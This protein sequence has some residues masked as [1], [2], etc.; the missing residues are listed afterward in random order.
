M[1]WLH[2]HCPPGCQPPLCWREVPFPPLRMQQ[3]LHH[4]DPLCSKDLGTTAPCAGREGSSPDLYSHHP[5]AQVLHADR[6]ND[7]SVPMNT[8][9]GCI[10][11]KGQPSELPSPPRR[12]GEENQ[13]Q[14]L[15]HAHTHTPPVSPGSCDFLLTKKIL[16]NSAR[17]EGEATSP[18]WGSEGRC[19]WAGRGQRHGQSPVMRWEPSAAEPSGAWAEMS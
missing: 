7:F 15:A 19:C 14:L 1:R 4:R 17:E 9:S 6:G 12:L 8:L 10:S 18:G 2:L 16:V 3:L 5:P 11:L 13:F